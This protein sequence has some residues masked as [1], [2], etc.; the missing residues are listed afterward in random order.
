MFAIVTLGDRDFRGGERGDPMD[1]FLVG[2][3]FLKIGHQVLHRDTAR[4][5]L[6][7]PAAVDDLDRF[8]LHGISLAMACPAR[9]GRRAFLYFTPNLARSG[10]PR[11]TRGMR[12]FCSAFSQ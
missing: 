5:E 9:S 2:T 7:S 6:R 3:P 8:C 12:P 11:R 10:C 1:D 4:R